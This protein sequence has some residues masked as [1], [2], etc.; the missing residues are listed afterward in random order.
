MRKK[1]SLRNMLTSM[2]SNIVNIFI[3]LIAQA[4]FIKILGEEYLGLNGLFS[5]II[6]MLGIVELGLGSAIV[7]NL[8]KPI[9]NN[10]IEDIKSL[11]KFYRKSYH[12]IAIVVTIIGIILIPLLQFIIDIKSVTVS[13]NIYIIYILFLIDIICSYMLSYKRSILYANQKN[14]LIN[15][16]HIIYIFLLN[17]SQLLI[18][19]FTKNYYLYLVVKIINRIIENLIITIIANKKYSYLIEKDVKPLNQEIEKDIFK[20]VKALF[21]H[22][23]GSF[24]V[25][26]TD[27]II[28]SKFLGIISVGLYSNYNLIMN[29]VQTLFTQGLMALTPSVGNMLVTEKKDVQFNTFK[30]VRF[31]NFWMACFSSIAIL[32]IM[33]SFITIWIGKKFL[34]PETVLIVLVFNLFQKLM[35]STYQTFKEAA[36]I[37][38][39]DRFVP[40]VESILNIVVSI[41]LVKRIGLVGVFIGT[42][43]SG[44]V[45]WFYSY[46]KYVYKKLFD[47]SYKDY[48]KETLG[49]IILFIVI[50]YL[51]YYINNIDLVNNI[52][53]EFIKNILI[54]IIVPNIL[55]LLVFIKNDNFKYY[56]QL[57]KTKITKKIKNGGF[58]NE[59]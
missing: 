21:F 7:Y 23:I 50:S 52:Y 40:L 26:G 55:M 15:I 14:Y 29:A 34:L 10:N 8:Y 53:F 48:L 36:G 45:L 58:D 49:Y 32:I 47:R 24:I 35:R 12:I 44:F 33:D 28:I 30:K 4:I 6:S 56:I 39:E 22:K 51:T 9:S 46:P 59:R 41:F 38:Y 3:G 18:L 17:I 57:I 1:N 20:K 37:Y 16:I 5:N 19:F 25:L 13:I 27:N 43:I 31:M 54:A 11:M 2:L 42:I